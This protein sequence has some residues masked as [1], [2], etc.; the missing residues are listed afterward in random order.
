MRFLILN[1]LCMHFLNDM[2]DL[3]GV[4]GLWMV[5]MVCTW[6][7]HV[8]YMVFACTLAGLYMNFLDL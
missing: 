7:L 4:H 1:V 8:F 2:L 6:F 3:D 5:R